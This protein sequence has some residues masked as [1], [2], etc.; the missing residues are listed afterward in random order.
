MVDIPAGFRRVQSAPSIPPGFRKAQPEQPSVIMDMLKSLPDGIRT[1]IEGIGSMAGDLNAA[2]GR[3]AA[4][5][6][7]K[8]G[9]GPETAENVGNV[10]RRMSVFA[11]M[12]TQEQA[13]AQS[14]ELMGDALRHDP[15]TTPGKYAQKFGQY[16][17]AAAVGP[18]SFGTRL[19]TQA[20]LPSMGDE[21]AG[22]MTEGTEYEP[23]ARIAGALAGGMLPSV[24]SRAVSPVRALPERLQMADQLADEGVDLTAGQRTGSN[25]LRYMESEIGGAR[26]QEFMER[27]GEQFTDAAMRRAG[28]GGRSTP[29]NMTAL[30][31]RLGQGFN[32]ISA[33]NVVQADQPLVADLNRTFQDYGRVLPTEQ[34]QIAQNLGQD[35]VT[36]FRQGGGAM[37]G[38]DYQTIRSR[39]S[40]MAQSNRQ[41][42]PEFAEA[43]RSMRNALDDAMTRS[44]RPEDAQEWGTLRREYGNM[45][46]L[47]RAAAGAGENA[48]A[49][50]I[51]PAQLRTAATTG[52]R[53]QYARA[54]GDF[55]EL[56]RAGEATMK[57]LPNSGTAS[58]MAVRGAMSL[59]TAI[60][61]ALGG[62]GGD[63]TM[64]ILGALGGAT[65]PAVAGRTLMSRPVQAYLSNQ[66]ATG[67]PSGN[68]ALAAVI[69]ALMSNQRPALPPK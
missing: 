49:G 51:S 4:W 37:P 11:G 60:G 35:I 59:P 41:R 2:G 8:V 36:R 32:D 26:A 50:I 38:T 66:L 23:Y 18:G 39:L 24:A 31:D 30:R 68:P 25:K 22:L 62:S 28:A 55:D 6:A 40:R 61:A 5:L 16:L 33:R 53:G 52:R 63:V 47:E 48:A 43:I 1:G 69:S 20:L 56:A 58:R 45:K 67:M 19:I 44:V 7:E 65:V 42:D 21:T 54:E 12:P 10:V 17:P 64:A 29:A 15:Q 57:P 9:A 14:D 3:G 46:T 34:R 13:V 27:Q